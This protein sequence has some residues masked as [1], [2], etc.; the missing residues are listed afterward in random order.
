MILAAGLG[1]RMRPLT[2][3]IPKP[4]VRLGGKAM[5]D[6]SLDMIQGAGITDIVVNHHHLGVMV[7]DHI[8]GLTEFTAHLSDETDQLLETGGGVARALSYL[9]EQPFFV[10]NS[11]VVVRD[12]GENSLSKMRR[13]WDPAKMDAL[14]LLHPVSSASGY[15]GKGDF[16]MEAEGRLA[17]RSEQEVA[18]FMFTGIQLLSPQLFENCP[19]APFSL[20]WVYDKAAQNGRLFGLR[21][22]GDWL[23]VGTEAALAAA[24]REMAPS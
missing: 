8:A 10:L 6:Y 12:A 3:R 13:M 16:L 21:H 4:L 17:R 9:G 15:T 1:R 19:Q 7:K 14:L 20:N 22:E 2:D 18:P 23:H 24:E 11:D 5:I